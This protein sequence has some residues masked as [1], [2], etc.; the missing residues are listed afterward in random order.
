MSNKIISKNLE[1]IPTS[2]LLP[3]DGK[4]NN[5]PIQFLIRSVPGFSISCADVRLAFTFKVFKKAADDSYVPIANADK[6]QYSNS[7]GSTA[8]E[9]LTIYIG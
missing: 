7:I 5:N 8:F 6:V 1:I 4:T 2:S 9:T 3:T